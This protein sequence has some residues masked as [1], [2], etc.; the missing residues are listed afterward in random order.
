MLNNQTYHMKRM[1]TL[2]H[3]WIHVSVMPT[4]LLIWAHTDRTVVSWKLAFRTGT[5]ELDTTDAT[6]II[7]WHVPT[8]G[9]DSVV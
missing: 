2:S 9:G 8:P 7:F 5:I 4:G 6:I 1:C 3:D